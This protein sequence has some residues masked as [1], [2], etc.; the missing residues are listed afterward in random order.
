[1]EK[2]IVQP[3]D[4]FQG[5]TMQYTRLSRL[6]MLRAGAWMNSFNHSL[7]LLDEP[8][9]VSAVESEQMNH[10]EDPPGEVHSESNHAVLEI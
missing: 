8:I 5:T 7:A 6:L 9:H 4:Q 10:S 3:S 1:M 2:S